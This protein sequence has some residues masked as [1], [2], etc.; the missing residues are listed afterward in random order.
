[1]NSTQVIILIAVIVGTDMMIVPLLLRAMVDSNWNAIAERH[2]PVEPLPDAVRRNFQSFSVGS[3][4][5]GGCIHVAADENHLHLYPS[6]FA[7]R[8]CARPMSIPWDAMQEIAG[9]GRGKSVRLLNP[10]I[11]MRGPRWCLELAPPA[12]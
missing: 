7:R 2:P 11:T 3:L 4:N 6:W 1:M 8:M 9:R 10:S 5:L 12:E